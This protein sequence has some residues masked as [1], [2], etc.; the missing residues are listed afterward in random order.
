AVTL[1]I[2]SVSKVGRKTLVH[3]IQ[4]PPYPVAPVT[5]SFHF[6][7]GRLVMSEQTSL[8]KAITHKFFIEK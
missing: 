3:C 6:S 8:R 5:Y 2:Q 7:K 1:P 4:K